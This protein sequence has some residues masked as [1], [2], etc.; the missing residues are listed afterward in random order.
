M[1][2]QGQGQVAI[3]SFNMY[4]QGLGQVAIGRALICIVNV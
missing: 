1:Y 3:D 4:S 2:S